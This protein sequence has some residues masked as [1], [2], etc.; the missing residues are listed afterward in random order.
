MIVQLATMQRYHIP[1]DITPIPPKNAPAHLRRYKNTWQDFP[2]LLM[3]HFII[4]IIG[5]PLNSKSSLKNQITFTS[6]KNSDIIKRNT[7]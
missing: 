2:V 7:K 5:E 1:A 4:F 6:W 3:I